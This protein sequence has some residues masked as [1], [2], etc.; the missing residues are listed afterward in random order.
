VLLNESSVW[1]YLDSTTGSQLIAGCTDIV[2]HN[3]TAMSFAESIE[4][5]IKKM[6]HK[7]CFKIYIKK[8]AI[9]AY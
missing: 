9:Y 3:V 8:Y 6:I 7:V 5:L 2:V 4:L 1:H